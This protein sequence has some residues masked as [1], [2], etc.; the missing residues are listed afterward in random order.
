MPCAKLAVAMA[1]L[2]CCSLYLSHVSIYGAESAFG[3]DFA[4]EIVS[5][6]FTGKVRRA[7]EHRTITLQTD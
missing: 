3:I 5:D 7:P 2:V 6:Q 4:I 1:K